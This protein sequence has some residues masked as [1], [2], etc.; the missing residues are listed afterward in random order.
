MRGGDVPPA[1]PRCLLCR[2]L[3]EA[4]LH[5][6]PHKHKMR[7]SVLHPRVYSWLFFWSSLLFIF[8]L[9]SG[10]KPPRETKLRLWPYTRNLFHFMIEF[11]FLPFTTF[12]S[13]LFIRWCRVMALRVKSEPRNCNR[14]PFLMLRHNPSLDLNFSQLKGRES[15]SIPR[16][17]KEIPIL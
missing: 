7:F 13:L 14:L 1:E 12:S 10:C 4:R 3:R 8:H 16:L 5:T 9:L 6:F 17:R 2:A 15:L 11:D